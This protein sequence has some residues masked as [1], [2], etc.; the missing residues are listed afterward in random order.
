[1]KFL[2]TND[3]GIDAPGIAALA[4]VAAQ[5][6]E[7]FVVAPDQVHSGC[8]H[9]VTSEG[10]ISINELGPGRWAISGTPADCVRVALWKLV[11]DADWILSGINA[12]GNLGVDVFMS[13]TVAAVREAALHAKPGIALSQ[14]KQSGTEWDWNRAAQLTEQSLA[15]LL[16]ETLT[17]GRFWNVNLPD[18][19]GIDRVPELRRSPLNP[20]HLL[21]NFDE[22]ETGIRYTGNYHNRPRTPGDDVDV[23]FSGDVA[24]TEISVW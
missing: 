15:K 14:Y 7:V 10:A 21:M 2:L 17:P 6:G 5:F 22:H 16:E 18:L 11:P 20:L 1:M 12:G 19:Y 3:D 13:G 9:R 4:E 23:C 24:I 8:G